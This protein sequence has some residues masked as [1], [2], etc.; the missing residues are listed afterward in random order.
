[1]TDVGYKNAKFTIF[2]QNELSTK[3][4]LLKGLGHDWAQHFNF[5]FPFLIV[6]I[7][8][9]G[10]FNALPKF[11]SHKLYRLTSKLQGLKFFVL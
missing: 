5:I 10:I 3:R 8:N 2:I 1:M 4:K 6:R 7:D 9:I 11:E